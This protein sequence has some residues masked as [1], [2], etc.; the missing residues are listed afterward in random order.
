VKYP[1][2]KCD[3]AADDRRRHHIAAVA[4]RPRNANRAT[5]VSIHKILAAKFMAF[6]L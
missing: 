2:Q 1:S 4:V 3:C 5:P 6:E